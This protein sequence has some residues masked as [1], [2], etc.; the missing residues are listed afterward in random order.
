MSFRLPCALVNLMALPIATNS[1]RFVV[2]NLPALDDKLQNLLWLGDWQHA[3]LSQ[4]K[5]ICLY[6][7]PCF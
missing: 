4:I 5:A 6:E 1:R 7:G 3:A 2:L